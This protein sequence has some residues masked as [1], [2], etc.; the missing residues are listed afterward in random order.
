MKCFFSGGHAVNNDQNKSDLGSWIVIIITLAAFPPVGILLL[1][2]QL[3]GYGRG[4]R[5]SRSSRHPYDIERER[6]AGG[7]NAQYEYH[8]GGEELKDQQSKKKTS[9]K[10]SKTA[11]AVRT[12]GQLNLARGKTMTWV[13][14]GIAALFGVAGVSQLLDYLSWGGLSYAWSELFWLFSFFAAGLVVMYAGLSRT[15]KGRR[16]QKYLNLIG[17]RES[18]SVETLASAMGYSVRKVCD[19]LDEMLER[20]L[21]PVGYLDRANGLL[22]LSD[23]G[24]KEPPPPEPKTPA[25]EAQE[26]NAILREIREVNDAIPDPV[27]S[28]KIDR[29]GEITGKI[30]EYQR[31]NPG[32]DAELRSFLDYY[33]PTTLKILR[34]YAQLDAQGIEGENINAAKERI[35]GMMDKVVEGFEKQ[36]DKLFQAETLDITSDVQV[37]EQMLQKDGLSGGESMTLGG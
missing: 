4:G 19:D 8:Y 23:E 21:L 20:G 36:L 3:M 17:K 14:G 7:Y 6:Q 15:K 34:A 12:P 22:V 35:E 26:D 27:M 33:L 2:R 31:K 5:Q 32:K 11:K 18:V 25:E 10:G 28:R 30:L 1:F 16:F 9:S 37:L 24:V 13:G 29:I